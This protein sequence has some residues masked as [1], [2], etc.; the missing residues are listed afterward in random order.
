MGGNEIWIEI[1]NSA[2]DLERGNTRIETLC[3][4]LNILGIVIM[5]FDPG[6]AGSKIWVEFLNIVSNLV[7]HN[8]RTEI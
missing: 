2:P 3:K 4:V 1:H 5:N 7:P 6:V 8:I